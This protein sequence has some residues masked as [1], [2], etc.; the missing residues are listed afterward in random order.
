MSNQ[1]RINPSDNPELYSYGTNLLGSRAIFGQRLI[2][3]ELIFSDE[4]Y[5]R[6]FKTWGRDRYYGTLNTKG[7][8]VSVDSSQLRP[9]SFPDTETQ[10][11]VN[12]VAD[13]WQD[14]CLRLRSLANQNIIF[15]DSPWA[16]PVVK[17]AWSPLSEEYYQYMSQNVYPAFN[18]VFLNQGGRDRHIANMDGF[19]AMFEQFV[20]QHLKGTGPLTVSGLLEGSY[21]SPLISGLMIEIHDDDYDEDFIKSFVYKD[22]NFALVQG[23]AEQ[24]GF[25]IDKN[26]PWRLV[27]DLRNPAMRE[28]MYGVPI[29]SFDPDAPPPEDCDPTFTDPDLIPRA[30]GYSQ[31]P[32]LE[33]VERRINVYVEG[34][35]IKPGYAQYQQLKEITDQDKIYEVF[36]EEAYTETW[37]TDMDQL[38]EYLINFYNTYADAIPVTTVPQPFLR[39]D[40][41][42]PR[43]RT[44]ER[45]LITAGEFNDRYGDPW[46]LKTFYVARTMER[47]IAKRRTLHMRAV[48][49]IMNIYNLSS[50]DN[51]ARALR[52]TQEQFIG[53]RP[54]TSLTIERVGD[55][56]NT[57]SSVRQQRPNDISNTRRQNRMRGNLY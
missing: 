33:D 9:L 32:G 8:T 44:I 2:Y 12:F 11:C 31:I 5:P 49:E 41:C 35:E 14:F 39:G 55:I 34:D 4:E 36:Y 57:P 50:N 37:H 21:L 27:A 43:Y 7:N 20:D 30:Y 10:F 29:I 17:K 40:N 25:A 56:M 3:N 23:I 13:A 53:P 52:Y 18:E 38:Q 15:R 24:Y 51:Y 28:Y 45:D 46:K 54:D 22:S 19:I 48:Q 6:L 16:A 1:G 42:A 26:I 47:Y